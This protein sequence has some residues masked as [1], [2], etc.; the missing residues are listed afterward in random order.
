M[1]DIIIGFDGAFRFLSNFYFCD[2]QYEGRSYMTAEHA[3]QAAKTTDWELKDAI[4]QLQSPATAKKMGKLLPLR[5]GWRTARIDVMRQVVDAKFG[6]RN[7]YLIDLLLSTKDI[8][9]WHGNDHHDN[10]WGRCRC[11][12]CEQVMPQDW[13]GKILMERRRV[14]EAG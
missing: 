3:Y 5:P 6:P 10:F 11:A 13:L 8:R 12:D 1:P 14:L 9:L 7:P 2:L 4:S